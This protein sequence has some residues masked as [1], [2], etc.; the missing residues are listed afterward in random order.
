M[1]W[2]VDGLLK[3]RPG[4]ADRGEE[5]YSFAMTA[6]GSPVPIARA[7]LDV[8]RLL[9]QHPGLWWGLGVVELAI[10]IA[11]VMG[12]VTRVALAASAL[13]AMLIWVL[14]EGFEGLSAGAT[15][16]VTGFPGAALLYAILAVL[17]WPRSLPDDRATAARSFLG[18]IGARLVWALLWLGAAAVQLRPQVGPG[19][20]DSTLFIASHEEPP[21][22]AGMD[23][24]ALGWLSFAHEVWLS[25]AVGALCAL[26]ALM[27]ALDVLPRL[28][29][30]AAIALNLVFWLV[31]QNF[32]GVLSGNGTDLGT[33]PLFVLLALVVWP[34]RL[35]LEPPAERSGTGAVG[36]HPVQGIDTGQFD[37]GSRS[38]S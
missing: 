23:R 31:G 3:F 30:G 18:G 4:L 13:L 25:A 1:F 10:G 28:A 22:L 33:A 8:G 9:L 19:A 29:L 7:I 38:L 21:V 6:M 14:G 5:A 20:L 37:S 12:R 17:I 27:V 16:I 36:E 35:H 34:R 2:F 32:G 11:L 24:A 15:S 26:L